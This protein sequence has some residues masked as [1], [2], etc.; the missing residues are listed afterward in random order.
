MDKM[1]TVKM[2]VMYGLL[3][4]IVRMLSSLDARKTPLCFVF[5]T[6]VRYPGAK[7]VVPQRTVVALNPLPLLQMLAPPS[8][9]DQ[10]QSAGDGGE[11]S[12]AA[13]WLVDAATEPDS[14][15]TLASHSL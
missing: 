8:L 3:Q 4:R 11:I 9:A 1:A 7:T 12:F 6:S 10:L 15:V 5:G 13:W 14:A 2:A